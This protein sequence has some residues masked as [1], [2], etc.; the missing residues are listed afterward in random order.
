[1]LPMQVVSAEQ[2]KRV[3]EVLEVAIQVGTA[4]QI[5]RLWGIGEQMARGHEEE[6]ERKEGSRIRMVIFDV[7]VT[8]KHI[9]FEIDGTEYCVCFRDNLWKGVYDVSV[10]VL[11][12]EAD[13]KIKDVYPP[14]K[15]VILELWRIYI[16]SWLK[17]KIKK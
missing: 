17:W 8:A 15:E 4:L 5:G 12:R 3:L 6:W 10:Q 9:I 14:L 1:M 7:D 16:P 2:K 13:V 11:H